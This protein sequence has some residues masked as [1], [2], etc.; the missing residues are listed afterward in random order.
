MLKGFKEFLMRGNVIDLATAVV[1]GAA[2][3]AVVKAFTDNIV[4][5]LINAIGG[6]NATNGLGF[7]ILH[8]NKSTFVDIGAV[9]SAV[10]NF[11]I[12]AAVVYFLIV[13]PYEKIKNLAKQE[14]DDA[15]ALSEAELLEQIRDILEGKKDKDEKAEE[16]ASNLV[17]AGGVPRSAS[18]DSDATQVIPSANPQ[19]SSTGSDA[20]SRPDYGLPP[21]AAGGQRPAGGAHEADY[22]DGDYRYPPSGGDGKH[23]Q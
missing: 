4:Q 11:L 3:T 10:I 23:N 15:T 18:Y 9:I 13:M 1:V 22:P 14:G 12:V 7:T 2:F 20:T 16:D 21:S 19:G 17:P 6:T 8:G 5:P